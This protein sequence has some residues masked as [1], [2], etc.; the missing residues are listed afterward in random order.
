MTE[1]D[2]KIHRTRSQKEELGCTGRRIFRP[3]QTLH[4]PFREDGKNKDSIF[5]YSVIYLV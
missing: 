1:N 5:I 3:M 2:T 4:C